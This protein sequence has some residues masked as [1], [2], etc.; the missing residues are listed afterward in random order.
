[1]K[2]RGLP[3]TLNCR[4]HSFEVHAVLILCKPLVPALDR[5]SKFRLIERD[6]LPMNA[7]RHVQIRDC[8]QGHGRCPDA[9]DLDYVAF[10]VCRRTRLDYLALLPGLAPWN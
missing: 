6:I 2:V 8:I 7:A 5:F 10:A 3:R 4:H 9:S 1:L